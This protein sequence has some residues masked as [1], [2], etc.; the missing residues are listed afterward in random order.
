MLLFAAVLA[1]HA[2]AVARAA[3]CT[4]D[5]KKDLLYGAAGHWDTAD[6]ICCHNTHWAER[7][8]L[9]DELGL[10]DA[11]EGEGATQERP[12]VFYDSVCPEMPLFIAPVGRSFAAWRRESTSHGWPSFR[13][14]EAVAGNVRVLPSGRMESTCGTHLGHNLPDSTGDRY[15]IDLVCIAGRPD[16]ATAQRDAG[17]VANGTVASLGGGP[18]TAGEAAGTERLKVAGLAVWG[19]ASLVAAAL[20]HARAA[21]AKRQLRAPGAAGGAAHVPSIYGGSGA[22]DVA[23]A[24]FAFHALAA[25]AAIWA[26]VWD[27]GENMWLSLLRLAMEFAAGWCFCPLALLVLEAA[28]VAGAAGPGSTRTPRRRRRSG[29]RARA[30]H[31]LARGVRAASH[32]A[33]AAV[34]AAAAAIAVFAERRYG[35]PA[36]RWGVLLLHAAALA[37]FAAA[38]LVFRR[39]AAAA[40]ADHRA[41]AV[42]VGVGVADGD[43]G[44]APAAAR[45]CGEVARMADLALGG[46]LLGGL[47]GGLAVPA[48]L[49]LGLSAAAAHEPTFLGALANTFVF[50]PLLLPLLPVVAGDQGGYDG[51]SALRWLSFRTC[52]CAGACCG[53][54]GAWCGSPDAGVPVNVRAVLALLRERGLG[55]QGRE[56]DEGGDDDDDEDEGSARALSPAARP[57]RRSR[58]GE[59]ELTAQGPADEQDDSKEGAGA[60]VRM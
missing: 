44:R 14:A 26:A 48:V 12:V 1:A 41:V 53:G 19:A 15:C 34:L 38:V 16:A 54:D 46:C 22:Y 5:V 6:W 30:T 39:R 55:E 18:A 4:G 49:R 35:L 9:A 37:C 31:C 28:G 29:R 56:G 13:P 20:L 58:S 23:R 47:A 50:L 8:G 59:Y 60:L 43:G 3:S 52:L 25:G 2:A 10:Y 42:A 7:R 27:G 45:A 21:A 51:C 17:K 11:L 32:P 40:Y 36:V 33:V 57:R 24:L